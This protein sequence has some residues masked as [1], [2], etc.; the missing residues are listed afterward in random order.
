MDLPST[1]DSIIAEGLEFINSMLLEFNNNISFMKR[2][3]TSC[4]ED[5]NFQ[6]LKNINEYS[7]HF[8]KGF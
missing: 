6:N 7:F 3:L 5:E 1:N 2:I 4:I 8:L